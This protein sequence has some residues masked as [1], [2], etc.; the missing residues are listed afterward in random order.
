M[1]KLT[2]FLVLYPSLIV[3]QTDTE[4][5]ILTRNY[6]DAATASDPSKSLTTITYFDGLGRPIQKVDGKMSND[7]TDIVTHIEYDAFGRPALSY[8][9]YKSSQTNLSF[10]QNAKGAT[11]TFYATF[12][13][14]AENPYSKTKF[15]ASPLSR[16]QE[17]AAPGNSWKM[18]NGHTIKTEYHTNE[19]E[20]VKR[21]SADPVTDQGWYDKEVLYKTIIKDENWTSGLDHTTEEFKDKEGRVVLKRT[22]LNSTPLDTYYVYDIYGNLACVI[23]P[24]GNLSNLDETCY[25]YK[26]DHRNR[27]V[28]KKIPGK[29]WEFIVYDKL[30][31]VVATGPALTPF[32]GSEAA[33]WLITKYDIFNRIIV[34]GWAETEDDIDSDARQ[35]LQNLYNL[36]T[37]INEKKLTDGVDGY[38]VNGVAFRYSSNVVFSNNYHVLS[39]NYYDNYD[40]TGAP[41]TAEIPASIY[42]QN[43]GYDLTNGPKGMPTGTWVR[44]PE[45]TGTYRFE[46]SYFLY[47]QKG[48]AIRSRKTNFLGGKTII[49]TELDFTGK[50]L[51]KLTSHQR[52]NTVA[53]LIVLETF[54][55]DDQQRLLNTY[56]KINSEPVQM[57][58]NY[59]YDA[60]GTLETK[61]LG[62]TDPSNCWQSAQYNYNVRGWLTAINTVEDLVISPSSILPGTNPFDLFRFRISYDKPKFP[63]DALFNGNISETFWQTDNDNRPRKYVY[64]YDALNR[65]STA[66][67]TRSAG[68]SQLQPAVY[69]SYNESLT[70]DS[71]GNIQTIQRNGDLEDANYTLAIDNLSFAYDPNSPNK[72]LNVTDSTGNSSGFKDLTVSS[73]DFTYDA[74]GNMKSDVNKEIVAIRYNHL[75]LPTKIELQSGTIEYLYDASGNKLQKLVIGGAK[76]Q[77]M[78]G[79]QYADEEL[80]LFPTSEGYVDVTMKSGLYKF[81]YVYNYTDHLG[82]VRLSFGLNDD[83][84]VEILGENNYYP[85]GMKHKNYNVNQKQY[86]LSG[87]TI[88]VST[89]TECDYK[90]KYNGKELQDELGLGWYDYGMRNYDSA[91]GRWMNLDLLSEV[92]YDF[93]PYNYVGNNPVVRSDLFGMDWYTDKDGN[94]TYDPKLNKD[95]A[96]ERLKDIEGAK[97]FGASGTHKVITVDADGNQLSVLSN[98]SLNADGSVT[99]L[100]TNEKLDSGS[101]FTDAKGN[102]I[103]AYDDKPAET[104]V[105][106]GETFESNDGHTYQLHGNEW[107]Q[108]TGN[109]VDPALYWGIGSTGYIPS[110][111]SSR[112]DQAIM[113]TSGRGTLYDGADAKGIAKGAAVD[114]I[115]GKI[116][117]QVATKSNPVATILMFFVNMVDGAVSRT[118]D[119]ATHDAQVEKSRK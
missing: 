59:Q 2:L 75:N 68:T 61:K 11:E 62:G 105:K 51:H 12:R 99:D 57:I 118:N 46:R 43:I 92:Y 48:R 47:D 111:T 16:V 97:Y 106:N 5:Y 35:T 24:N 31:R 18:A 103:N 63:S 54:E 58:G 7:G 15:E 116:Q 102:Q 74:Y 32:S 4:N 94:F 65:L 27:L 81:D 93:S 19:V 17:Q 107:V 28:E 13:G 44:V 80:I 79:F 39:V 40:F 67:Y 25:Q 72:L 69:G 10:V 70:Y 36:D 101:S 115:A 113:E 119:N 78:D 108:L 64:T 104:T 85:F 22:Y 52:V 114:Y 100:V 98:H 37:E 84:E 38:P 21:Y 53:P 20:E 45:S 82:N 14:G 1:K 9:P 90:Y 41:I 42:G 89:C 55:Y 96:S 30:D 26:Y 117:R 34:T 83:G 8:L 56:H 95:N 73:D 76:T 66:N 60:I 110:P 86:T 77:Y 109:M 33:G 87:G 71:M 6:I 23:P 91:I 112:V 29:L 50:P 3:S 88:S 49:D